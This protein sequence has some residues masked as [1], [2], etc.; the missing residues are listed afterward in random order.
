MSTITLKNARTAEQIIATDDYSKFKYLKVNRPLRPKHVEEMVATRMT[1]QRIDH[2]VTVYENCKYY[3]IVDGQHTFES[4]KITGQE[5][6]FRVINVN[7]EDEA[8][9]IILKMNCKQQSWST[10]E[11]RDLWIERGNKEYKK[12]KEF[13]EKHNIENVELAIILLGKDQ[14]SRS[15]KLFREGGYKMGDILLAEKR[16]SLLKDFD[17]I[18]PYA[19]NRNFVRAVCLLSVMGNYKHR[20]MMQKLKRKNMKKQ[21]STELYM[22]EIR[23][24]Y[25]SSVRSDTDRL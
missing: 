1:G 2:V 6:Q 11:Y 8:V 22:E 21:A 17:T 14:S 9:D 7:T 13:Q 25:N 20:K 12:L 4:A 3:Y 15:M 24:I 16:I 5:F 10:V 23:R 18:V 19:W